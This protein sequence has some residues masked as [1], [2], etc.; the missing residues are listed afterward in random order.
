MAE[1]SDGHARDDGPGLPKPRQR[2]S[3][4][5][6]ESVSISFEIAVERPS[7]NPQPHP[8]QADIETLQ[9]THFAVQPK[10]D[11]G[12]VR[13]GQSSTR[14]LRLR[15]P[16]DFEQHV[17]VERFPSD[18]NFT[19]DSTQVC[20]DPHDECCITFTWSPQDGGN[21]RELVLFHV[22][23][24]YRLQAVVFGCALTNT[25]PKKRTT[26][27]ICSPGVGWLSYCD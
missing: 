3:W 4:F 13:V 27:N 9:L 22:D 17:A 24:V 15:N 12:N 11:F 18:K 25:K 14:I 1:P 8:A 19:V 2:R 7:K 16:S 23:D 6:G 21:C 26:V 10:I 20:V 5:G